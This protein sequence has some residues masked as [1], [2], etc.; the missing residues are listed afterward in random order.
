MAFFS[1]GDLLKKTLAKISGKMK[2]SVNV[3]FLEG[4]VYT[5]TGTPVAQVAFWNEYGHGGNFPAPPRPF[6]RNMIAEE[7]STWSG[8]IAYGLKN[9]NYDAQKVMLAMGEDIKGALQDSI[10]TID[11]PALS[12]TTLMLRKTFGNNPSEIRLHDVL[13]AQ[14]MVAEGKEG[15]T[16]TQAKPLIWTG[17][18][19]NSVDYEVKPK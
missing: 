1:G 18:L 15:A 4:A 2:G 6:F 8:K 17:H 5:E 16:G 10:S 12:K 3:G 19:L 14:R 9:Y 13:E 11:G 7:S